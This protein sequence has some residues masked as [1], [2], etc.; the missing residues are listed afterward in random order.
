MPIS[1][2]ANEDKIMGHMRK[3][4]NMVFNLIS[5][6]SYEILDNGKKIGRPG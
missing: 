4:V 2:P 6:H 3:F 1:L 5:K